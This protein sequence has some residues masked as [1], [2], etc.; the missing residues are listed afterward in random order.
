MSK[1]RV[2][3]EFGTPRDARK[4]EEAVKTGYA[5]TSIENI[6]NWAGV[7]EDLVDS[8]GRLADTSKDAKSRTTFKQ[9]LEESKRNLV[10][11]AELQKSL[12][13]LDRARVKR[14]EALTYLLP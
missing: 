11:L 4:V 5:E 13:E 3:V 9:L 6:A 2:I 10:K 7:E 1:H 14:I 12:E 8:Y